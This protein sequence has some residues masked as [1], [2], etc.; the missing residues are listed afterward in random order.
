MLIV[1]VKWAARLLTEYTVWS[2]RF[3]PNPSYSHT[4][5]A[6]ASSVSCRERGGRRES[7]LVGGVCSWGAWP[8]SAFYAVRHSLTQK[9]CRS[10]TVGVSGPDLVRLRLGNYNAADQRAGMRQ[11]WR[12]KG[13]S[14]SIA[15]VEPATQKIYGATVLVRS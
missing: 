10:G 15:R 3:I 8:S 13:W 2:R 4:V 12:P 6:P 11:Q 14:R 7:E 5:P 9:L 1:G